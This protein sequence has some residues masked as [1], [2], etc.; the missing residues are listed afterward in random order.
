M[1]AWRIA[2]PFFGVLFIAG[3]GIVGCKPDAETGGDGNQAGAGGS[4]ANAAED[5]KQI[6]ANLDAFVAAY[7]KKDAAALAGFWSPEGRF[8]SP[9]SGEA[10]SG[11]ENIEKEYAAIF[12]DVEE[13]SL[14]VE[15]ESLRFISPDV[16]VEEGVATVSFGEELASP[17]RYS[18]THVRRDG[19][20][21]IDS[22][23][24]TVQPAAA[25]RSRRRSTAPP[26]RSSR[27]SAG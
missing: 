11:R 2:W 6:R 17:S 4:P 16:A 3:S 7:S 1:K 10:M 5:E 21:L 18:A 23:R 8:L 15:V 27:N 20:W 25:A 12:A 9:L 22:V 24:E 19:K 14:E 13:V 26:W